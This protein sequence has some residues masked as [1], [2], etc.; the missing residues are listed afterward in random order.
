MK[1]FV[2]VKRAGKASD[3]CAVQIRSRHA[4]ETTSFVSFCWK[5]GAEEGDYKLMVESF[6]KH[7]QSHQRSRQNLKGLF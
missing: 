4:S 5:D 3:L 6:W 7:K 1:F 2:E